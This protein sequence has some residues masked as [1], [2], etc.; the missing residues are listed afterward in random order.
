[1]TDDVPILMVDDDELDVK[2]VKRAF[3]QN[4]IANPLHA[5]A[6]GQEAMDYLLRRGRFA[7]PAEAPRPGLIIL[8]I[9]MPVMNGLE[10]L[11]AYKEDDT[12]KHIP[13]VVLTTSSE[14]SDRERS[15]R[16]GVAGYIVKPN[17]FEDFS[18]A[19]ARFDRYWHMCELP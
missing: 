12:F 17:R 14:A 10:F 9:N 16:V 19:I 1:M 18:R 3:S 4:K 15:Y 11:E 7:P 6:N 13:A 5:V 2:C 8:D